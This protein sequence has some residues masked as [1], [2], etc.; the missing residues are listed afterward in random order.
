MKVTIGV[1]YLD[2]KFFNDEAA[3]TMGK[4][5]VGADMA[6]IIA[7]RRAVK[8]RLTLAGQKA[9]WEAEEFLLH[10]Y[11]EWLDLEIKWDRH[12]GCSTCPCSPGFK[13][14][15]E[16]E[17][18]AK[19]QDFRERSLRGSQRGRE[20][21]PKF[22]MWV[23]KNGKH[24]FRAPKVS[25]MLEWLIVHLNTKRRELSDAAF[26]DAMRERLLQEIC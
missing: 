19:P 8:G 25:Q 4:P 6:K 7:N 26:Q 24:D 15:L 18:W 13:V 14:K 10:K 9:L 12:A 5:I 22:T 16:T 11:G 23:D 20:I 3:E 2:S 17:G 1:V 21:E